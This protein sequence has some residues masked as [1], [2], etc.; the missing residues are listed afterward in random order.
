ML[1]PT[2]VTRRAAC[3]RVTAEHAAA[4]TRAAIAEV[5]PSGRR[6]WG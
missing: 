1:Y 2:N 3:V 4:C 5:D 6:A